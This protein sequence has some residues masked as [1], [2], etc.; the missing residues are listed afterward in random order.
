VKNPLQR[1][2]SPLEMW[3][4]DFMSGV[5]T[6]GRKFRTLNVIDD[7]NREA[8]GI[9][10][11]HSLPAMRVTGLLDRIIREQEKPKAS[12]LIMAPNL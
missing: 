12:G 5:L 1:P 2:S 10:V 3:S 8:I 6:N 9:K 4:I 11:A 7:Y